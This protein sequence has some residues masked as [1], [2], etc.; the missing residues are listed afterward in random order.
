MTLDPQ[1]ESVLRSAPGGL[2]MPAGDPTEARE[3]FDKVCM[4]TARYGGEIEV[5]ATE[6]IAVDG[7]TGPLEGRIYRPKTDGASATLVFFHGGGFA[8]GSIESHDMQARM[9]CCDGDV[10]VLSV[11]YRL[12]PENKFPAAVDDAV[13][14]TRWA[15]ANVNR[16]GGDSA[17]VA[18][19][20]DSAGGNLSAVVAQTLH[21]EGVDLAGQLLLY[22]VTDFAGDY[23][24]GTENAEGY[25][26]TSRLMDW[27]GE[28][29]VDSPEHVTDTRIS[30]LL[31]E[32]FSGLPPAIVVTAQYDP[33]RDEGN[34]YADK[35]AAAGVPTTKLCFD[36]MI[37]GFFGWG[38]ISDAARAANDEICAAL[39]TLLA[40][41]SAATLA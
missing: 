2:E 30:P 26:L 29:Y 22:P 1:I 31:A 36:G 11:N 8:I 28:H 4:A 9:L 25:F 6:D 15:I 33:L 27:F 12:A 35:L 39:K 41:P 34:A 20:G 37:H 21:A 32:D 10:T 23:P 7:A 14:A 3:V 5:G 16:L 17:R 19:G 40:Q 24:S 38:P 13:A 18:V